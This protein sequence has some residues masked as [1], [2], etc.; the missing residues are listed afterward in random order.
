MF[1][2]L[3]IQ[4]L[5]SLSFATAA[6]EES[7]FTDTLTLPDADSFLRPTIPQRYIDEMCDSVIVRLNDDDYADVARRL[8]IDIAAIK[9]VVDVETGR[10]HIG[11]CAPHLPIVYFDAKVFK[12]NCTRRGIVLS[13]GASLIKSGHGVNQ[14]QAHQR[15]RQAIEIDSIAAV[16][17]TFWGMFQIGGFN[18][19]L[20]GCRNLTEFVRQMQLSEPAQLQLFANFL[21]NT[22]LVKYLREKNW[23]AFARSY[24]GPRYAARGYHT[25]LARAYKKHHSVKT[26]PSCSQETR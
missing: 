3:I 4:V 19:K 8:D 14:Q 18:W 6:A 12:R 16:E 13:G 26:A 21:V 7:F 2:L 23:H 5:L 17:S 10:Q 15:L 9:A 1:R 24:N 20:C 11:F 25:R 22:G